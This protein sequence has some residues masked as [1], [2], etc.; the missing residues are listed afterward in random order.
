MSA[1]AQR[2]EQARKKPIGRNSF[3]IGALAPT[4]AALLL[5]ASGCASLIFQILWIKQL[6]LVVGIEVFATTTGVG[7]FFAGLALG[8]LVLGRLADTISRPLRLYACLEIGA[9]VLGVAT[10]SLL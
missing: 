6:S 2:R 9:A 8:S 7:A 4:A 5:F 1:I 10:T 3:A